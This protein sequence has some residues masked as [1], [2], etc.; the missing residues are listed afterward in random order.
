MRK[1]R[2]LESDTGTARFISANLNPT[3]IE[4][5]WLQKRSQQTSVLLD[6]D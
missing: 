6:K 1:K 3:S 2:T 5:W 4:S